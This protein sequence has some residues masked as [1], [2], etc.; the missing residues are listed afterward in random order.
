I[1]VAQLE[2]I[3]RQVAGV[4]AQLA[5]Q[6]SRTE[7]L[8]G[9]ADRQRPDVEARLVQIYK[10][11]R[12]GYWRLLLDVKSIREVGRAY[13]TAAALGRIDRDRVEEHRLTMAALAK[14]RGALQAR[15]K[16]LEGLQRKAQ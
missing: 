15:A 4:R 11:G 1:K 16:E 3:E 12:A 8:K 9:E 2:Q 7:A 13:R 10:L 5:A 14:E 6:T